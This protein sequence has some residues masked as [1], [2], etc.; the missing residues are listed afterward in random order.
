MLLKVRH[1]LAG[2][3]PTT[4]IIMNVCIACKF[5]GYFIVAF[6]SQRLNYPRKAECPKGIP[7]IFHP[8]HISQIEYYEG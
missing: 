6:R 4:P 3:A 1:D 7:I 8:R 5:R 2:I